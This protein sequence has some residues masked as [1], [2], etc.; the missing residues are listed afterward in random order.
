MLFEQVRSADGASGFAVWHIAETEE[1]LRE[2]LSDDVDLSDVLKARSRV[3]R[4][5]RLAV[6]VLLQLVLGE[7]HPIGYLPS[8]RPFLKDGAYQISI[9]HT[10]HW[11]ALAWDK[12]QRVGIDIE[13]RSDRVLRAADRFISREERLAANVFGT[14]PSPEYELLMWSTKESAY[15]LLDM[16]GLDL[17]CDIRVVPDNRVGDSGTCALC[18]KGFRHP[19]QAQYH[20]RPEYLLTVVSSKYLPLQA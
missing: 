10:T 14:Q 7:G 9:S 5:E 15:K 1:V 8:G 2:M 19:L 13:R 17:L 3:R 6:R 11:A 12:E 20:F 4:T 18:A 16:T